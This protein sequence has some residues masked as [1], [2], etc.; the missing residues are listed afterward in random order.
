MNDRNRTALVFVGSAIVAVGAVVVAGWWWGGSPL[1]LL[2]TALAV[3][4]AFAMAWRY[5]D[6][7]VTAPA[8]FLAAAVENLLR[9][10]DGPEPFPELGH[11]LLG[12][13]PDAVHSLTETMRSR[14]LDLSRLLRNAEGR[15]E[16]RREWLEV[17]LRDLSE[18]VLVCDLQHHVLFHNAAAVR[19]IGQGRGLE[20]SPSL[21]ALVT[22]ANHALDCL[23][24]RSSA[25]RHLPRAEIGAASFIGVTHSDKAVL[26]GRMSL[27]QGAKREPTGY[28]V[29]L[30]EI[31]EEWANDPG[32]AARQA[33]ARDLRG[34]LGA[35]SAA[36]ETLANFPDM[37]PEDR[38]RFVAAINEEGARIG[39]RITS[40]AS[41]YPDSSLTAWPIADI[42]FAE[43]FASIARSLESRLDIKLTMVGIPLWLR[44]DSHS[45]MEAFLALFAS[46]HAHTGCC[47][48]DLECMLG[49][50]R[51]YLDIN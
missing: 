2:A 41:A 7:R 21:D 25:L 4:G 12:R 39:R 33:L 11:H 44:G 17:A 30:R 15:L 18:A 14:R 28:V 8:S 35:L 23:Q 13:L 49:D 32:E 45:L 37:S 50:R 20:D 1:S 26:R 5:I 22:G 3:G 10:P 43:L 34:P 46:L 40:L 48:F 38:G 9:N 27:V 6:H 36:A 16:E 47:D 42:H 51:V 19:I 29:A 31:N 24:A